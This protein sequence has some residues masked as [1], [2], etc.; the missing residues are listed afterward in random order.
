MA[1]LIKNVRIMDHHEQVDCL[2]DVLLAPGRIEISPKKL[3]DSYNIIDGHKKLLVPGLIDLHVHFR[4]PGF[5]HKETIASGIKASLM[6]GVTSALVMPNT[7]PSIDDHKSVIYQRKKGEKLGFDLMVSGAATLGLM[8]EQ[9]SDI[10]ALKKA[11]VKAITDDGRPILDES[12]MKKVLRECRLNDLVCMQHAEDLHLS[13]GASLT[14]G[15]I[16]HLNRLL[17]QPTMAESNLVKRDIA[18]SHELDARYHV[19]HL[20]SL[21]SL[22]LVREAKRKKYS[23]TCEVSPH[24]LLLTEADIGALDTNKKMNPP[25]RS[26]ADIWALREGLLDGSID[27]VASDHAPHSLKEKSQSFLKAP[28]G[29]VGV[30]TSILVLL[31]LVKRGLPLD[32]AIKSMTTGPAR[33]LKDSERIG[34]MLGEKALKNAVLLDLEHEQN[35]GYRDIYGPSKNSAFLGLPLVGKVMMTFIDGRVVYQSF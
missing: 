28:F 11:G 31:S 20:S 32:I 3:P 29:V 23:V 1:I 33:I 4:E 30:S 34:T 9:C 27:A 13:Q 26:K 5:T 6:G 8:G 7:L 15:R 22:R 21:E 25:L 17:G 24:H 14:L 2:D 10:S 12:L 18:L 19:L 35:F 16:S